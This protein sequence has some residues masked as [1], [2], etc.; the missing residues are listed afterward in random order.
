MRLLTLARLREANACTDQCELFERMFGD[1]VVVTPELC[2]SVAADFLWDWAAEHLLPASAYAEYKRV[3]DPAYA[4]YKRVRDP[5][6]AKY[7]RVRDSAYA[8]YMRVV[9]P[10][11]AEYERVR[12][13]AYAE[14]ER[15]TA[16]TF[17]RL[18]MGE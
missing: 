9:A 13:S 12:D 3:R 4:E 10:A 5:A 7:M 14:Y 1:S 16:E 18:Y 6:L 2:G 15:V 8:E 11:Y 17:G